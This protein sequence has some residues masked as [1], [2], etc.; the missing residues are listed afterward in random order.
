VTTP[1]RT[2][3]D[4]LTPIDG[5]TVVPSDPNRFAL[6][7]DRAAELYRRLDALARFRAESLAR[8]RDY[9]VW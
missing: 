7:A 5:L 4:F 9:W 2:L 6:S 3:P 8:S 1:I